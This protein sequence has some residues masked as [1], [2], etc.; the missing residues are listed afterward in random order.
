MVSRCRTC[1]HTPAQLSSGSEQ[2]FPSATL[3]ALSCLTHGCALR[4]LD[5]E[6][7]DG[8]EAGVFNGRPLTPVWVWDAVCSRAGPT[9]CT[10]SKTPSTPPS[11]STSSSSSSSGLSSPSRSIA[12][13]QSFSGSEFNLNANTLHLHPRF[14]RPAMVLTGV[15]HWQ[16]F[17]VVISTQYAMTKKNLSHQVAS[18]K[19]NCAFQIGIW[20]ALSSPPGPSGTQRVPSGE[21]YAQACMSAEQDRKEAEADRV[22]G[23]IAAASEGTGASAKAD[24]P[25]PSQ[26]KR[27]AMDGWRGSSTGR[28]HPAPPE[29]GAQTAG[30][31]RTATALSSAN[32][33]SHDGSSGAEDPHAAPVSAEANRALEA[34]VQV[35]A[36]SKR[37][38]EPSE[39]ET[40]EGD[41]GELGMR[42]EWEGEAGGWERKQVSEAEERN[43]TSDNGSGRGIGSGSGNGNGNGRHHPTPSAGSEQSA[44]PRPGPVEGERE[45]R[46]SDEE[47]GQ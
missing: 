2:H 3:V 24:A 4:A 29:K 5:F 8:S 30:A 6:L 45:R 1:S 12:S 28:V 27:T 32:G 21:R 34:K 36:Q 13:V 40:K 25:P 46:E 35:E 19:R 38:S 17:L 42:A 11:S 16:L 31:T 39:E 20:Y 7:C 43:G 33:H 18:P 41:G 26:L 9:S 44:A 22:A 23:E 47:R 37:E 15:V 10:S 14:K